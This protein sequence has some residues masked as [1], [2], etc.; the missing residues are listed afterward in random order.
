MTM[1]DEPTTSQ[2]PTDDPE[3]RRRFEAV[4]GAYLEA[5]D[6]GQAPHR[7]EL[8]AR[9]TD[10]ASQLAEFFTE[11]DGHLV[12]DGQETIVRRNP[13]KALNFGQSLGRLIRLVRGHFGLC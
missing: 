12:A 13:F 8:L 7:Q 4:L 11:Q 6:A 1:A 2:E 10:L 5:L 3:R 9:H